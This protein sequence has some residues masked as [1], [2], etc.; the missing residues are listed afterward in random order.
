MGGTLALTLA[1]RHKPAGLVL[2]NPALQTRRLDA[3]LA[4][5]ASWVLSGPRDR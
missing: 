3:K 2:V 1:E 5:P 4:R